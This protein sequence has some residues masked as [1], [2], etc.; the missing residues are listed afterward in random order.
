MKDVERRE[1]LACWKWCDT[2]CH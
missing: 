2:Y 1:M